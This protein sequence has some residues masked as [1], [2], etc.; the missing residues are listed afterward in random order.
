MNVKT[1]S[2]HH[3]FTFGLN[4]T[5]KQLSLPQSKS[6]GNLP[7]QIHSLNGAWTLSAALTKTN[8]R[9]GLDES[10][11]PP[12]IHACLHKDRQTIYP[13]PLLWIQARKLL[14]GRNSFV[15]DDSCT[16]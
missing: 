10:S 12:R 13:T 15:R 1:Y 8:S 9:L 3:P 16:L 5:K 6:N 11:T 4:E 7:S 14:S 2:H